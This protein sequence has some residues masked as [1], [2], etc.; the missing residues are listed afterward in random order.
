MSTV[1]I[2]MAAYNGEKYLTEQIS[3]ILSSYYQD[4]E[5]YIYDD[6]SK[7]NTITMIRDFEKQY[8]DK[9]HVIQ[10]KTNLGVTTNFLNALSATTMDYIMFCD[11]DDF[12]LPNKISLTLKR[13]RHM[14]AQIGSD[15][16]FAVFTDA[17]IAD[18]DLN[19]I[20]PSFF[21]SEH[22]N[23]KKIDLPH[24]LMENKLIGCTVM[25]NAA[26]RKVLQGNHLP[27][28]AKYH[29]WW[30]ALI[31][32]SLGKIGFINEST[33]LYRQHGANVVGGTGFLSY[34]KK[35]LSALKEQ[36][37]AILALEQQAEEFLRLYGDMLTEEK[38]SIIKLFAELDTMSFI[39][40]RR[41]LLR[42]GFLKSGIIRNV[43]LLLI[44]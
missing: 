2:V 20:K 30:V 28:N 35:R 9:V 18:Q 24:I 11:Q 22:L 7:D 21:C 36:K 44:I 5:L 33:L 25:V 27:T 31:A 39:K 26:L 32:V 3:S 34:V 17:C 13:M 41:L 38:K 19:I 42:Y 12:W 8:P 1:A 29:D 14:E 10:N 37:Q 43:A 15:K 23:P 6:G 16:P 40:K 4:F